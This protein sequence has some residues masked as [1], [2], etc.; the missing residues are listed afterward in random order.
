MRKRTMGKV[1]TFLT[2]KE[3]GTKVTTLKTE[4]TANSHN[5]AKAARGREQHFHNNYV[6]SL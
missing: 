5:S 6:P 1:N 4:K 3:D 2:D